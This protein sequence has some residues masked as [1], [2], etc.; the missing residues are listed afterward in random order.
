MWSQAT[1][2]GPV[3]VRAQM[4]LYRNHA[5]AEFEINRLCKD[6]DAVL[7]EK[8][9]HADKLREL[10]KKHTE[11]YRTALEKCGK[12]EADKLI[13]VYEKN[14]RALLAKCVVDDELWRRVAPFL[15]SFIVKSSKRLYSKSFLSFSL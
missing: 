12:A 10:Q 2:A 6:V 11:D 14:R 13:K 4:H 1:D 8:A 5:V 15:P 7:E 9:E 3:S